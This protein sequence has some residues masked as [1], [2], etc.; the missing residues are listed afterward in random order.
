ME[1]G[2]GGLGWYLWEEWLFTLTRSGW[3]LRFRAVGAFSGWRTLMASGGGVCVL[4]KKS[5][6]FLDY[7]KFRFIVLVCS[8]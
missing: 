8:N 2:S 5:P 1:L 3:W 6:S 4:E 7:M